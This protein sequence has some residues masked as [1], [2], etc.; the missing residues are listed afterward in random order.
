MTL[1]GIQYIDPENPFGGVTVQ[2]CYEFYNHFTTV[3]LKSIGFQYTYKINDKWIE[4][5]IRK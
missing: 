5:E 2:E 3:L 4:F 1:Y